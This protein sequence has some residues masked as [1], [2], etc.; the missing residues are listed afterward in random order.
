MKAQVILTP[1]DLSPESLVYRA[2][3]VFDVLRATTTITAALA[4]GVSEI[5][6]FDSIDAATVAARSFQGRRILCGERN[7]L[8]PSGFDLG[9]SPCAFNAA[10][11]AGLT[12]FLCT[13]N[14]T[15]AI[16]AA[17]TAGAIF[18]G[19][20]VNATSVA[21]QLAQSNLDITLL[22]AGTD[23][24]PAPEDILGAGAV[25]DALAKVLKFECDA[26]TENALNLF[27]ESRGD[28]RSALAATPGGRN[29]VSAGLP[30][31]IDFA[32]QLD[33]IPVVGRILPNPL[34]IIRAAP[35]PSPGT[36][37]EGK[38]EGDFER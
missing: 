29:I 14:G 2:V 9:N 38:D 32:A 25:L 30:D 15:R 17:R 7:C 27:Q 16:V 34:R 18:A 4:A 6:I 37:G 21:Q 35:V 13:T 8:P 20:L 10:S 12:A 26:A 33:A 22:C 19:A 24:E 11:H 36:P 28:L 1:R 5:R 23:G 31:D 3:V